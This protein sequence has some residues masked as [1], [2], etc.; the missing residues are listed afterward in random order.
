MINEQEGGTT[1][2]AKAHRLPAACYEGMVSVV[3]TACLEPRLPLFGDPKLLGE[4][5]AILE[6]QLSRYDCIAPI[7][8]FMPDHLH[9]VIRGRSDAARPSRAFMAFKHV[10]GYLMGSRGLE[11]RWQKSYYDHIVR[12]GED[13]HVQMWYVAMNP[14]RKALAASPYAFPGVGA[15]GV[16]LQDSLT[17]SR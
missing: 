4:L 2:Y 5:V 17:R 11:A 12:Q 6:T 1:I 15:I 3:F 16:D 7:Y 9:T 10:S 8:C 13:L 14:V